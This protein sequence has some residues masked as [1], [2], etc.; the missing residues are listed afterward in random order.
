M[1]TFM[2][3]R[4][5]HLSHAFVTESCKYRIEPKT[6]RE[7]ETIPG[8][9]SDVQVTPLS[10]GDGQKVE[11]PTIKHKNTITDICGE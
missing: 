5:K 6:L 1:T 7:S 10:M 8:Q 11:A 3:D 2:M 4:A 9:I